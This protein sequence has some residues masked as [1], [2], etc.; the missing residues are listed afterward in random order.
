VNALT[1]NDVENRTKGQIG[2]TISGTCPFCSHTRKQANQRKRVFAIKLKDEGFAV[3]NCAHCGESG[4]VHSDSS[5][6]VVDL[7]QIRRRRADAERKEAKDRAER[8]AAA[9]ALWSERRSFLGSPAETYL[10]DTRGLGDWLEAFDL[11]ESLG[12]HYTCPFGKERLPCMLAL[13]RDIKSDEPVA[14]HRTALTGDPKP[15]RIDRLSL[16]PVAGGAVKLSL[17][18]DVTHGL[19][20]AE[21]IETALSASKIF[22]FRPVWSQPKRHCKI[23]DPGWRR[24]DHHRGRLR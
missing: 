9:L 4:Y 13:V 18:G 6:R 23:P 7:A 15:Q 14:I 21:G 19:M 10:R 20:I 8:T 3:F 11:D 16:G 24:V 22:Q 1:W 12:F 5:A 17:D 2:R